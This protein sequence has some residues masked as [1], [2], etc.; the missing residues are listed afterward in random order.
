MQR[1]IIQLD[2]AV[3]LNVTLHCI[4]SDLNDSIWICLVQ[5]GDGEGQ[6]R[7]HYADE[8][9]CAIHSLVEVGV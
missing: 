7:L 9:K 4:R 8:M 5:G 6:H 3:K 1:N 2:P